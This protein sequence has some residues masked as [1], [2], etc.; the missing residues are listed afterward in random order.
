MSHTQSI[1]G[2]VCS[3]LSYKTKD[4]GYKDT[5][6]ILMAQ[7]NTLLFNV[8]TKKFMYKYIIVY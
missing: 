5:R 3:T 1:A 4:K 2:H 7:C 8:V 6:I